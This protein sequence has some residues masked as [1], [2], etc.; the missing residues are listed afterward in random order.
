MYLPIQVA[1][2]YPPQFA[3]AS[4]GCLGTTQKVALDRTYPIDHIELTVDFT[5]GTAL[6][7]APASAQ[8]NDALD[9][10]LTLIQHVNLSIND[11]GIIRSVVDC[12]G[13]RLLEYASLTGLN[14]DASTL[15][16][17][18]A[19]QTTT[20]AT[21]SS[22]TLTYFIPCAEIMVAD[23][24]R[25]R[26]A[27]PVHNYKQDPILT[28]SFQTLANIAS[29]GTITN[30]SVG[31]GLVRKVITAQS[32]AILQKTAGTRPDGYVD[33]DLI[34]TPFGVAPG[35]TGEQR[36][37][38][39]LTG[40]YANLL[41]SSY[42]GGT[43]ITR[44]VL[45]FT[46]IGDTIAHGFS[47][48]QRWRIESGLNVKKEW[49]MKDLRA[50]ND[51]SRPLNG[52]SQTT[53]PTIGGALLASTNFRSAG[54]VLH[55]FL[56]DGISGDPADGLGSVLDCNLGASLKMEI[57]GSVASVATNGSTL[58]VMGRRL[59]GD[60]SRWQTIS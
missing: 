59:F 27:L 47:A 13:V 58:S 54:S 29:A 16:L 17:V 26:L 30:F 18:A 37:P 36:F 46:G 48:E 24:L 28:L 8:S 11:G 9:N 5:V 12:S 23:P 51:R 45:D 10:I 7:L 31:V 40:A 6:T 19:S 43:N 35:I 39:P 14:L 15:N 41:I 20:L 56:R 50:M 60:L 52:T 1:K 33:W 53:S 49:R 25:S 21:N 3:L 22:Y 32:E 55:D 57:I 4:A 2:F 34:E 44:N 38:L 42:L